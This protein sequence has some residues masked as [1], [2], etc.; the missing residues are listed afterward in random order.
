MSF[1][2]GFNLCKGIRGQNPHK[3]FD[4]VGGVLSS[5]EY[6]QIGDSDL[7]WVTPSFIPLAR[8]EIEGVCFSLLRGKHSAKHRRKRSW[9]EGWCVRSSLSP[10][11]PCSWIKVLLGQNFPLLPPAAA[12]SRAELLRALTPPVIKA[13]P[14]SKADFRLPAHCSAQ[15]SDFVTL[16][17]SKGP[18]DVVNKNTLNNNNNKEEKD[19]WSGCS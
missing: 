1:N 2:C 19:L 16:Y 6:S 3:R 9:V 5:S 12:Q 4:N 11:A 13:R 14:W 10:C 8:T 7:V 17:I 18:L 15:G